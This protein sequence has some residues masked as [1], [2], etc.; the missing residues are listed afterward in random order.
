MPTITSWRTITK[1]Y[2]GMACERV[3]AVTEE[4]GEVFDVSLAK[5][6]VKLEDGTEVIVTNSE[7]AG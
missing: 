3:R 1:K 7:I 2:D 5:T 6:V 4:D